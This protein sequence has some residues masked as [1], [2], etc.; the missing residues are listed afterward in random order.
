MTIL[1]LN[2]EV[3]LNKIQYII[4]YFVAYN[5]FESINKRKLWIS[6]EMLYSSSND[7]GFNM[8]KIKNSFLLLNLARS[9]DM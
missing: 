8:I 1:D 7:G 3:R 9:G 5:R 6:N 2:D 4:D